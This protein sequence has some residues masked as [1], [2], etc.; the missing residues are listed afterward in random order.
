MPETLSAS[1]PSIA[2]IAR[3]HCP[4]CDATMTLVRIARGASGFDIRTFDCVTCDHAQIVTVAADPMKSDK[5]G[6][7]LTAILRLQ[8]RA[9]PVRTTT[10]S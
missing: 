8:R 9:D 5:I 6:W 10:W 7:L 1:R 4:K 3:P 2:D